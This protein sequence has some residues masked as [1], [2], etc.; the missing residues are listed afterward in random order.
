MELSYDSIR[1]INRVHPNK[2]GNFVKIDM[3]TYDNKSPF[4]VVRFDKFKS[5]L[6]NNRGEYQDLFREFV[7]TYLDVSEEVEEGR[8]REIIDKHGNIM[9]DDDKPNNA[10]NSMVGSSVFDLDRVYKQAIPKTSRFYSGDL[11]IG[12]IT[13]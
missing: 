4:L 9:P 2:E 11:G 6:K 3:S 1:N 13:W 10:T 7:G 12:I 5:W 8:L